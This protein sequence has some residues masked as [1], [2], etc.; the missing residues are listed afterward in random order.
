MPRELRSQP[1]AHLHVH[2]EGAM[3]PATLT[4]LAGVYGIP[5]ST[6]GD[7]SFASFLALYSAACEALRSTEDMQRV[8]HEVVQDAAADG[9]AWIEIGMLVTPEHATRLHLPDEEA[10][11]EVILH[12]SRQAAREL[13]V[14]VGFIINAN[15]ARPPEEARALAR[16]AVRHADDG[17]VGFGLAADETRGAPEL[18]TEAF[19]IAREA[20]LISAPHAGEHGGPPSVRGAL[21][22]LGARRIAHGVR[23]VEDPELVRR[24]ADELVTLDVCPTSNVRLGVVPRI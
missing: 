11:L 23:A 22:A 16:L 21:D 20:G 24:L 17:V 3:R 2:L 18:F 6:E 4:E 10:V 1:K 14:G 13:G 15:R 9:A 12:A 5:A 7:G 19:T 8:V